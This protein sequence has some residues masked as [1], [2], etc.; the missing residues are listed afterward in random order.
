MEHHLQGVVAR[1]EPEAVAALWAGLFSA[2]S[3]RVAVGEIRRDAPR[4]VPQEELTVPVGFLVSWA[5]PM[6]DRWSATAHRAWPPAF[7][8]RFVP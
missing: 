8:L 4:K 2:H 7:A 1:V 3:L 5:V 6:R